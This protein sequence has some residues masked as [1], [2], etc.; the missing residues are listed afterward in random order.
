MHPQTKLGIPTSNNTYKRNAPDNITLE[1]SL[2]VKDTVTQKCYVTLCHLKMHPHT[3]FGI[4]TSNNI[5]DMLLTQCK[6][7]N[8]QNGQTVQLLFASRSPFVGKKELKRAV[9]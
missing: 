5:G 8:T 2:K 3:K 1:I 9:T 4:L 7:T 6:W